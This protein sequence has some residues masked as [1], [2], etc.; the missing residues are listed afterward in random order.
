MNWKFWKKKKSDCFGFYG[1]S[2]MPANVYLRK[3]N[4]GCCLEKLECLIKSL[5][6]M[7]VTIGEEDLERYR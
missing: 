4:C 2:F 1:A 7:T 3:K 6:P 5:P